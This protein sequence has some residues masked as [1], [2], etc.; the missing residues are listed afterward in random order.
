MLCDQ[1]DDPRLTEPNCK[2]SGNYFIFSIGFSCC[3]LVLMLSVNEVQGFH[4]LH[5]D[6][7]SKLWYLYLI[8]SEP[9]KLK[10]Q[11]HPFH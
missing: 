10:D 1:Q 9:G 2:C 5:I 3:S 4:C 6:F 7:G 11:S 8:Y